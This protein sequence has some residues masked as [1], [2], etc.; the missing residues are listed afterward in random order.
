M[1]NRRQFLKDAA[2]ASAGMFFLG[3]GARSLEARFA[4]GASGGAGQSGVKFASASAA[5]RPWMCTA[6]SPCPKPPRS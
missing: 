4:G 3:N 1:R 5:S 6:T 2:G